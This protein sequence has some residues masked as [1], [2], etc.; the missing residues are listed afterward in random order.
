[1]C[2]FQMSVCSAGT[3]SGLGWGGG[4]LVAGHAHGVPDLAAPGSCSPPQQVLRLPAPAAA[5]AQ[6]LPLTE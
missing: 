4:A 1:M 6:L 2:I 3:R 5:V